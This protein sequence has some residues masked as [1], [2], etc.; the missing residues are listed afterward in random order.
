MH[1]LSGREIVSDVSIAVKRGEVLAIIGE[2]GSGKTSVALSL[3]GFARPGMRISSGK[4]TIGG[5][6]ILSLSGR[7][8]RAFQGGKVSLVP[9]NPTTSF[10]PRMSIGKQMAELLAAH[11][12]SGPGLKQ[13]LAEALRN[14]D[15]PNDERFLKR[16]PFELSGGQ[17]QRIA[18]AMAFMTSPQVIVMDEPT[19]GLD[20]STQQTILELIARLVKS[21]NASVV[22]VTHDLA[23]VNVVADRVAVMLSGR[24]VEQGGRKQV[25]AEPRDDYTRMLLDAI[26]RL[27]AE[28]PGPAADDTTDSALEFQ[29]V[30]EV[31]NLR[32]SHGNVEVVHG[33]SFSVGRG[34]CVGLVGGSGSGKTTTGRCVTGLHGNATGTLLFEGHSMPFAVSSRSKADLGAMQI[35]FQNPDRSLNPKESIAQS[36]ARAVSLTGMTDKTRIGAEVRSLL[37]RVRLPQRVIDLYPAD[38]SGGE[39]QRVAVARAL[40]L[41]PKLL[42]CDEI[43]SALDVSVQAAVVELLLDLKKDGL[44]MLFITHNLPLVSEIAQSIIIM[45]DG[46]IVEAGRTS[47]V[48]HSP[49]HRYTR[50]LLE[51][52]P[53]LN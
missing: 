23:V 1:D 4:I 45:K 40:A 46:N 12:H 25:F 34:E 26:P 5:T 52:A 13:L 47:E 11:G 7:E 53:R 18:I 27:V 44:A 3:L 31:K 22:Y 33:I 24:I 43:T 15:L 14:V 42:V 48:L 21:S 6:D 49:Q 35:V 19:T 29:N 8:R 39:R 36:I 16:Y 37:D 51:A 20:V 38:L 2:S 17:L 28:S 32:A 9:Q 50:M 30:L 41:K 10:S